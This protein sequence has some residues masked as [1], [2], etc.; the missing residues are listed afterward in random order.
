M[1]QLKSTGKIFYGLGIAGIGSLQFIYAGFRPVILPIPPEATQS[2]NFFV[3]LTAA[4]LVVGGLSIVFTKN[5]KTISLFLGLFFLLFFIIG[6]LLNRIKYNPGILGAWTDALKLLALSG[7]AFII[8]GLYPEIKG[9]G[10]IRIIQKMAQYGKYFFAIMLIV[11]GMDHFLYA[12]FVKMLV[13]VWIP[14]HLFWTYFAG[15]ALIASGLAVF[16]NFKPRVISLLLA[17]ML[18]IWLIVLHIPRAITAPITDNGNEWTSVFECL[19]F[20]G[21]A[22][23]YPFSNGIKKPVYTKVAGENIRSST[24]V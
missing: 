4:I 1:Q 14:G 15:V 6:H 8:S 13:P 2:L 16:L 21:I 9:G 19:A 17:S 7:G 3:H 12:D 5:V 22:I 10:V 23:L 18:F 20:S 11:F 24:H